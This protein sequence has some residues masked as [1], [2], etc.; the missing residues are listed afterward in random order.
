LQQD[1]TV[2]NSDSVESVIV[3]DTVQYTDQDMCF[4]LAA[5]YRNISKIFHDLHKEN[6][7][8]LESWKNEKR[9]ALI[10]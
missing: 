1:E 2:D 4:N 3:K 8:E 5:V 6:Y 7:R 9:K 10:F